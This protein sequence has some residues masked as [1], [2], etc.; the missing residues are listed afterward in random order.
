MQALEASALHISPYFAR[1]VLHG[2][3][4]CRAASTQEQANGA[5]ARAAQKAD[6]DA[7]MQRHLDLIDRL[8]A[9][10]DALAAQ[11]EA[12]KQALADAEAR[13]AAAL[14]ALKAGWA[15]ELRKQKEAWTAAEKVRSRRMRCPSS[16]SLSLLQQADVRVENVHST[17]FSLWL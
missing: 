15:A 12:G 7:A 9:D 1:L 16:S 6:A 3:E 14:V 17:L 10:K 8:L 11:V 13:Q 5:A 4:S 2:M